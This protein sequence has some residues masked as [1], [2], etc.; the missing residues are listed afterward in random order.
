MRVEFLP[1][2]SPDYN[3][4]ELAFSEIKARIRR[5]GNFAREDWNNVSQGDVY[6]WLI[7]AVFSITAGHAQA[8]YRHC[9]YPID[10]DGD[11]IAE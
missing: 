1:P 7:D 4:I 6:V 11:E 9:G 2:Y 10:E 8:F 5:E 3:P